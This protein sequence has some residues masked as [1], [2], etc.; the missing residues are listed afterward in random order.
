MHWHIVNQYLAD[1]M[2]PR[3]EL[4]GWQLMSYHLDDTIKC[5]WGS[6]SP[7]FH[8]AIGWWTLRHPLHPLHYIIMGHKVQN[9][10]RSAAVCRLKLPFPPL[11]QPLAL[12]SFLSST[13]NLLNIQIN[14]HHLHRSL[15]EP[16]PSGPWPISSSSGA[17]ASWL[18]LS[19]RLLL[20][21]SH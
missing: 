14:P 11:I 15:S 18:L 13:W 10:S 4:G 6:F 7:E 19:E 12:P 17:A 16:R 1:V 21:F 9:V 8:T 5:L 2:L 20:F 3:S